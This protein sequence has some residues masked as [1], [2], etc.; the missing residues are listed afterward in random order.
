[1][2]IA[3]TGSAGTLGAP[4]VDKLRQRGHDVYGIELQHSA[5][6]QTVRA[7]VADYRQISNALNDINPDLVYHLA[8]EFGRMNGEE[9]Y[10]QVWRTNVIGTRNILEVQRDL[11]FKHVFASSSEVYGETGVDSI[12]ETLLELNA[13]PRL[14]NDYAISKRVNEMQIKNFADRYGTDTMVLRFFNA[15]GPGE[16]FHNYR[17]VVCL[18]AYRL[19]TG[20]QITVF[21]GYQRVFMYVGDFI[22]TLANAADNFVGNMTVNVGGEEFVQVSEVAEMLLSLTGADPALITRQPFDAHN[23]TSKRPN[24]TRAKGFLSHNPQTTLAEGLP[25]TVD[26]LRKTYNIGG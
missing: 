7:D 26:W 10:E 1:M 5:D 20:Q 18:F 15:Y 14:T 23:V 11:G 22:P 6:P 4:L 21:D 12:D 19:L 16:H 2:K 25:L 24:I 3:V 9:Y 17:S 13:Q 8:A